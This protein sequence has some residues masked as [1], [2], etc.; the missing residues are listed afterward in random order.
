MVKPKRTSLPLLLSVLFTA[1]VAAYVAT[2]LDWERSVERLVNAHP[3]W[4]ALALAIFGVNYALRTL[5]FMML[6][7]SPAI[8][9]RGLLGVTSLY[10]MFNYLLPAKSGELTYLV[11]VRRYLNISIPESTATLITARIFDFGVV[12][13]VLPV[14]LTAFFSELPSWLVSGS[15]IY[16]I[17]VVSAGA[18]LL[19]FLRRRPVGVTDPDSETG[20]NGLGKFTRGWRK[21]VT[22]LRT[23][24]RRRQY[25]RLWLVTAAIWLCVYANFYCIVVSIGFDP[26][27]LEMIVV[28]ILLV[29]LTLLP[30][31]GLANVGTHEAAWVTA[32]SLFGQ[33]ME[34][35]LTIAVTSHVVLL[36]FVLLLGVFGT[37][38]LRNR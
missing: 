27:F 16:C 3:S 11:L 4:L 38:L 28:S 29:P 33:P 2:H 12:A 35:A 20:R 13:L 17:T 8:S 14:V 7:G 6:L 1:A 30:I 22:G 34:D 18:L 36:A 5:R 10:G 15:V 26:S 21:M 31:Q 9:V 32:L 19:L 25:G 24:D 23:I 37:I